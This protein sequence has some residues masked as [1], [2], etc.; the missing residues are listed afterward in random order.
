MSGGSGETAVLLVAHGTVDRLDDLPEFLTNIRRGRPPEAELLHEVR[1]RYEAIGGASPLNQ[2]N[3]AIARKLEA[4]LGVPVRLAN[5]LFHPYPADTLRALG[6]SRVAVVPLAQHSAAVYADSVRQAAGDVP[7]VT[8][9]AAAPNWGR[10]PALISAFAAEIASALARRPAAERAATT[11][12]LS[13]HSLPVAVI[14]AGDAYETEFRASAE[15]IAA[16]VRARLPDA[17]AEHVV[18]F[19]SQGMSTGPGGR[20]MAWLGP[21]LRSTIEAAKARGRTRVLVAP[22]GFL[23]DHV[24]IL[25]DLDVEARGWGEEIGIVVERTRSPNDGDAMIDVLEAVAR[26]LLAELAEERG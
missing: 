3:H 11:L 22:V 5:R 17:F 12:V 4:R 23:A 24:E 18:A 20:P 1:R 14:Q 6:A 26:P 15:A 13:A 21:D 8:K 2:I 7:A 19:Q 16:E 9:I 25:Y 10:S